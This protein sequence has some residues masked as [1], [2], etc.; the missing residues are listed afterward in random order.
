MAYYVPGI[1]EVEIKHS[2]QVC[3]VDK[4]LMGK[5]EI[6]GYYDLWYRNRERWHSSDWA[7]LDWLK[8][9]FLEE[10]TLKLGLGG[11]TEGK[12]FKNGVETATRKH[13]KGKMFMSIDRRDGGIRKPYAFDSHPQPLACLS[14]LARIKRK[15]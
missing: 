10:L 12:Y 15:L 2:F 6:K 7:S 4:H 8:E 3:S 1:G 14:I 13:V 9:V 11:W 5:T